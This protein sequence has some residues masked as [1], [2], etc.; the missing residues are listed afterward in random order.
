MESNP[1]KHRSDLD[2]LR[3]LVI[4]TVF[5]FHCG[6]FFDTDGWHVKNP[7][8]HEGVM[9][10]TG[11]LVTWMMPLIFFI[12]GSSTWYALKSRS[13]GTFVKERALRLLVPLVLGIFTHVAFQIYLERKSFGGFTGSFFAFYPHYFQGWYAFGGNFAWM[14]LH[15]WYLEMLFVYSIL[16]L[17]L[18]VFLTEK[19][20]DRILNQ[21]GRWFAK[22]GLVYLLAI[23]PMILMSA[24]SP[25]SFWGQGGFGGWPLPDYVFIFF[26]GFLLVSRGEIEVQIEKLR[27]VSLSLGGILSFAAM[28]LWR[29]GANQDYGSA[30]YICFFSL[31]AASSWC[32]VLGL[33]GLA[34][35]HLGFSNRFVRY[36]NDGVLPFYVLHQS[37]ILTVGF[38]VVRWNIPDLVKFAV[39]A[40]VSFTIIAGIYEFMIRRNNVM[41]FLFGMKIQRRRRPA[42]QT[43]GACEP[44]NA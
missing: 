9:V 1:S 25:R 34:R 41:R 28:G 40:I 17:P 6:R 42:Y 15:L 27:S 32:F 3:V 29:S 37:V 16:L 2:W 21:I 4:L 11:F 39:I 30:R 38:Y 8:R 44:T 36:A 22:P 18:F 10:W 23:P 12:S 31:W 33:F 14:G 26:Y 7:V 24:L 35:R 13:A 19:T 43:S 20:G 5:V